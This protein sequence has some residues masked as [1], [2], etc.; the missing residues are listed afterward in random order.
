MRA[1]TMGRITVGVCRT[2]KARPQAARQARPAAQPLSDSGRL[3]RCRIR[4]AEGDSPAMDGRVGPRPIPA[5]A[6]CFG[7]KSAGS[8]KAFSTSTS[9]GGLRSQ[10]AASAR[11]GSAPEARAAAPIPVFCHPGQGR[12][13]LDRRAHQTRDAA[14]PAVPTARPRHRTGARGVQR[15]PSSSALHGALPTWGHCP[16]SRRRRRHCAQR[17]PPKNRDIVLR[18]C[19]GCYS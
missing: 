2:D 5:H 6:A 4:E 9:Q 15:R 7:R 1:R 17:R 19:P 18:G 10:T 3:C 16:P 11:T 8:S 12:G 14:L 13:L